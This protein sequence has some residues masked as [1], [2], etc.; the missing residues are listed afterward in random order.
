MKSELLNVICLKI[1]VIF[2]SFMT[3]QYLPNFSLELG[4]G[5]TIG[6]LIAILA[7]WANSIRQQKE[8][9]LPKKD[10][11]INTVL[12]FILAMFFSDSLTVF[13]TQWD[14]LKGIVNPFWASLFIGGIAES[15]YNVL[16][17]AEKKFTKKIKE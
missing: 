10:Y 2:G 1:T 7:F 16:Q 14:F 8:I 5:G 3:F 11:Y 9:T 15:T 4:I 13:L 17:I 12:A 6:Q